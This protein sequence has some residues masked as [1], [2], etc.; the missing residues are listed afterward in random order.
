M[1]YVSPRWTDEAR[2]TAAKGHEDIIGF[3]LVDCRDKGFRVVFYYRNY[4][5]AIIGFVV[6]PGHQVFR[7]RFF[8]PSVARTVILSS[9]SS[10]DESRETGCCAALKYKPKKQKT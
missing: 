8:M 4:S 3:D 6:P 9:D 10:S 2:E 5:N 1:Q 7:R